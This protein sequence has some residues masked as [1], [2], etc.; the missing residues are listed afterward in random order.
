[1][2]QQNIHLIRP[3]ERI[4][5]QWTIDNRKSVK[6]T[7]KYQKKGVKKHKIGVIKAFQE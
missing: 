1:M 4:N 6:A 2:R 3:G 5:K 7:G